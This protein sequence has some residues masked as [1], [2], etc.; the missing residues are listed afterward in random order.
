[1]IEGIEVFPIRNLKQAW[2]FLNGD[3]IIPPYQLNR[4]AF[5]DSHRTYEVDFDEVKGQLQQRLQQAKIGKFRD[6]LRS[7]AKTDY[8]FSG[9]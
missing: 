5:F 7:K 4:R 6:D 8:K 3:I 2:D 1:M 9:Q